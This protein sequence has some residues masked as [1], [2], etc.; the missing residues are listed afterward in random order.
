MLVLEEILSAAEAQASIS[1]NE[2]PVS[3]DGQAPL[4]EIAVPLETAFRSYS[5]I[6]NKRR[7]A[8]FG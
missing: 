1:G 7:V 4:L 3:R 2:Q 8:D 5:G 6:L